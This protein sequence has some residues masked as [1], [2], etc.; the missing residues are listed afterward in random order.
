MAKPKDWMQELTDRAAAGPHGET[1]A[2][3]RARWRSEG[4]CQGCGGE[5]DG[6][7]TRCQRCRARRQARKRAQRRGAGPSSR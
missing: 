2:D 5:R 1:M 3:K 6:D 7:Q 4:R